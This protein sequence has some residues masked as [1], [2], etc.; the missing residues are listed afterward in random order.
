MKDR[1]LGQEFISQQDNEQKD[2][3]WLL[4]MMEDHYSLQTIPSSWSRMIGQGVIA[5]KLQC[6]IFVG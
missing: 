4:H 1:T 6:E 5:Y 2:E 3:K